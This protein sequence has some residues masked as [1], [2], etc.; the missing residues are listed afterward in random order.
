MPVTRYARI[1]TSLPVIE[2]ER[3]KASLT[4]FYETHSIHGEIINSGVIKATLRHAKGGWLIAQLTAMTDGSREESAAK[5]AIAV[6][7][8]RHG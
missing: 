1:W 8:A 4:C 5:E 2:G 6:A 3:D 7:R